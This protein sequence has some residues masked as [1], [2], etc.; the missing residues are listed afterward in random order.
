MGKKSKDHISVSFGHNAE[1]VAGSYT[2]IECGASGKKI[3]VDYGMIQENVSLLKEYQLNQKRPDFKPKDINYCFLTHAHIDHLGSFGRLYS[4]GCEASL[5]IP[6]GAKNLVATMLLDSA[7]IVERDAQDLSKKLKKEYLPLFTTEDVF[8]VLSYIKEYPVGEKIQLDD[9][10]EFQMNW[11][12]HIFKSVSY[13]FWIRNGSYVRKIVVTGDIG[14]LTNRSKF[15]EEFV[16]FENCNLL[17]GEATYSDKKRSNDTKDREKDI[18]KIKAFVNTIC[19]DRKGRVLIPTFAFGR[20]P[21][22]LATLYDIFH[23]DENFDIPIIYASPLGVT[24]LD[25][26]LQELGE[27][28][29]EYLDRILH[30]KNIKILH[31]FAELDFELKD[32]KPKVFCLPS[33]MMTSSYSVYAATQILPHSTDGIMFAGFAVEGSLARKIKEKKTKTVTIDGKVFH[34]RCQVMS[35]K[36]FSSHATYNDLINIYSSGEY[37]KIAIVHSEFKQKNIF[38]HE[39]ADE[40][41]KKNRTGK[42]ICVN[43]STNIHL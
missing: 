4:M 29:K 3:L 11:N 30:W 42:I 36:S 34:A 8:N 18:E 39:L 43:K 1:A 40:L 15:V 26:F 31:S 33:G 14:N 41:S 23:E 13:T 37:D 2:L 32:N 9:N 22:I 17:I 20:S 19:Q 25:V 21:M 24:L 6:T 16:P 12:G 38:C 27:K 7:H 10:I 28:D 35:L 5:I